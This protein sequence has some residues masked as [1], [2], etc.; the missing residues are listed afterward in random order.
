MELE[1]LLIVERTSSTLARGRL[2]VLAGE[3]AYFLEAVEAHQVM[4]SCANRI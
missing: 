4:N 3:V 2:V 1:G